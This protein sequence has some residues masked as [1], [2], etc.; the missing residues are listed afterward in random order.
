MGS[1]TVRSV[2]DEVRDV[3]GVL[4]RVRCRSPSALGYPQQDRLLWSN[5]GEHG[6]EI[7]LPRLF[8]ELARI[9]IG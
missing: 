1:A 3:L 6:V 2:K 8:G 7:A 5:G 9:R 4:N